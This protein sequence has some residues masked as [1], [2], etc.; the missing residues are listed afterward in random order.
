MT[1]RPSGPQQDTLET[2]SFFA[3]SHVRFSTVG[4]HRHTQTAEKTDPDQVG[5]SPHFI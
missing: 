2:L 4:C 1:E 5:F 3:S